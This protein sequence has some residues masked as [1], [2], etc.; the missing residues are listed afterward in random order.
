[1][2]AHSASAESELVELM[3]MVDE[4]CSVDLRKITDSYVQLKLHRMFTLLKLQH[5]KINVLAFKKRTSEMHADTNFVRLIMHF[6]KS[7]KEGR[8]E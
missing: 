6:I 7:A 1:L 2:L 5:S 3:A 8:E 4:K